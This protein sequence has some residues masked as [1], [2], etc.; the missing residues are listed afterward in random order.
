MAL[1]YLYNHKELVSVR[2]ISE[3]LNVPFDTVSKVLQILNNKGI[4]GS[5]KGLHGGYFLK[6]DFSSINLHDLFALLE[7]K[8]LLRVC[9]DGPCDHFK[10]C[11]IVPTV[12]NLNFLIKDFLKQISL[13]ELIEGNNSNQNLFQ[14]ISGK[15]NSW[16]QHE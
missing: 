9:D 10:K 12:Y 16:S 1:T 8:Q 11:N 13:K 2:D 6:Q 4:V 15:T 5:E 3:N 7:P 14:M